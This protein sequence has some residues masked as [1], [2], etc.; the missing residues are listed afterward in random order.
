MVVVCPNPPYPKG[1]FPLFQFW[2][3]YVFENQFDAGMAFPSEY[4]HELPL[5]ISVCNVE[6]E[7]ISHCLN[8]NPGTRLASSV[9]V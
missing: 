3:L 8:V 1:A 7:G 9:K 2:S 4:F 5:A 6:F